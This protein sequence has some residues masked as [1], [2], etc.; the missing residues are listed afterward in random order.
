MCATFTE[1]DEG[2][3]VVDADGETVGIIESV[4]AGTPHVA[5]DPGVTDTIKSKL[6]WGEADD[7]TY[8]LD[9][10]NVESVTGDEVRI[11]RF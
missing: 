10:N 8:R 5:P 3:R 1:D 2:K 6:G 9:E 7:E 11:E 4:E